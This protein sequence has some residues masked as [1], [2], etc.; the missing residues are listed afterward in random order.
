MNPQARRRALLGLL[1]VAACWLARPTLLLA[2][3][4]THIVV[5]KS[6]LAV[7]VQTEWLDGGGYR[8]VWI[9]I[10]P[11]KPAPGDRSFHVEFH[12][13]SPYGPRETAA[14][15]D[16]DLPAGA[17]SVTATLLVPQQFAWQSF[18][19]FTW[20]DGLHLK[21]LDM[22]GVAA[23][24]TF[25]DWPEGL[26]NILLAFDPLPGAAGL[27]WALARLGAPLGNHLNL[28]PNNDSSSL[29]A[30]LPT[31]SEV[32]GYNARLAR[33]PAGATVAY[34]FDSLVSV[35]LDHLP[36]TWLGY[37]GLDV[38]C[39]SFD[40][41]RRL[42]AK[43]APR[44][45]A[46][47]TWTT[48]G[49]NLLI[50]DLGGDVEKLAT[51][52]RLLGEPQARWQIIDPAER[53]WQTPQAEWFTPALP[54]PFGK[55]GRNGVTVVDENGAMVASGGASMP[56]AA[57]AAAPAQ[58][59]AP[60]KPAFDPTFYYRK[61]GM[62]LIAAVSAADLLAQSSGEWA[63]ILNALSPERWAWYR[64]H[65]VSPQR[66]N[67]NFWNLPILGVGLAPV[68]AFQVLITGFVI[69]IGPL[70]YWWLRRRGKLHL[71]VIFVPLCA[72]AVTVALLGYAVASDGLG[73][74]VRVRSFTEIDQ[75]RGEAACWS[76]IAYYAGLAPSGGLKF[77]DATAVIPID[78]QGDN[79]TQSASMYRGMIWTSR[80]QELVSGWLPSRAPF[81][82]LTVRS[83][84]TTAGLRIVRAPEGAGLSIENRLQTR[85]VQLLLADEEGRCFSADMVEAGA[86]VALTEA[87]LAKV[88]E[89]FRQI[90]MQT[91][92]GEPP[93][94]DRRNFGFARRFN[95]RWQ[96]PLNSSLPGAT[97]SSSLLERGISDVFARVAPGFGKPGGLPPRTYAAIVSRSPE[98]DYG[99]EPV[100]EAGSF[101]LI[102]GK[103]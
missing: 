55:S 80:G 21:G 13:K 75:R 14:S 77:D 66:A 37:S 24:S 57:V 48:A 3:G 29:A 30:L 74:R 5:D 36:D 11:P 101:H 69:A 8:P 90:L 40:Q 82:V 35:P 78:A 31:L 39:L 26:P 93:G 42:A 15:R 58:P 1:L 63:A 51:I 34:Q 68:T 76:R 49:G 73:V 25:Q 32:N 64:R 41:A 94:L 96:S 103:W 16:I 72:A 92:P 2:N 59:A 9:T 10:K 87:D 43:D 98:T 100:E 17:P 33:P 47:R 81:Q 27:P 54:A 83:R 22:E 102:L 62:G 89:A 18:D 38:I 28:P 19:M 53:G 86:K 88:G 44:W 99:V 70:N 65:G 60:A 52:D 12:A 84:P 20:E 4:Y 7:A 71:L 6:G 79:D 97:M 45:L 46:I 61:H 95:F 50:S 85:I 67:D 91:S 56:G 23:G